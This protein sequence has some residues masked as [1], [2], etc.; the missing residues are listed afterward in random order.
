MQN[1]IENINNDNENI[2]F[3]SLKN[4]ISTEVIK[5]SQSNEVNNHVHTKFSFSP[6]YPA[7]AAFKA[8]KA[9]LIAV[10]SMDHD[11]I[12]GAKEMI[13]ACE[14]IGIGSTVGFELRVNLNETK[15]EGKKVNNPDSENIAYIAIH[16]IPKNKIDEAKEFLKPINIER[17]VRNKKMVNKLNSII[18]TFGIEEIDFEEDIY[19]MSMAKYGGSITERHILFAFSNKILNKYK[20]GKDVV[21]FLI[22]NLQLEL[23][24]KIKNLLTDENNIHYVYDLLGVLKSSFIKLFFIQPNYEECINIQKVVDFASSINAIPAYA[25]LG[26]IT[27]SPTGDKKPEKFEDEYLDLLISEIKR[28][29][30][31]AVTYMPPRNTLEQLKRVQNLCIKNDLMEISGVDINSSRQIFNCPEILK[32][33]FSHLINSTWALIAHEKLTNINPDFSLFGNKYLSNLLL[34]DKIKVYSVVGKKLDMKNTDKIS[35]EL[36]NTILRGE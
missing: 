19:K 34:Y 1:L 25:Y 3:E 13:K 6:Y 22:N 29:G 36:I 33:D 18:T 7:M 21:N 11:S 9:G 30:F 31:K 35:Q 17:N 8:Y 24:E 5:V 4:L 23:T 14:I 27:E 15:L 12:S 16:G 28:I 26:D 2:R 10:G 32:P 20:K